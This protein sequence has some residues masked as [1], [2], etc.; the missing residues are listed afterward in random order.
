[1]QKFNAW[2]WILPAPRIDFENGKIDIL[3]GTQMVSKGLDF[4]R[5]NLVGIFDIDRIIHFPDFRS[6]ERAY[7]LITQVSG[8]AGRKSGTGKVLIQTFDPGHVVL[9]KV[10]KD[11]YR[12]FYQREIQER[13]QYHYPP[14][15]RMVK[16]TIRH[17]D[18]KAAND[19]ALHMAAYLRQLINERAVDGPSEPMINRVRNK[20]L[21]DIHVKLGLNI[22]HI[23][24]IK[25]RMLVA[26]DDVQAHKDY[27][28]VQ[29]VFDVDP[30]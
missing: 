22:S 18:A 21:K 13:E 8:R 9:Q 29:V 6:H 27:R 2:I 3:V 19:A 10:L 11:N 26:R 14:F 12:T 25:Q 1:M 5:V 24:E 23:N 30:L 16:I 17:K 15:A 4:D 7:Q 28:S 20:Y